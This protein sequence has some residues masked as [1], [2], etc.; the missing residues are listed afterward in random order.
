MA[1]ETRYTPNT[2]MVTISTSNKN[3]DGSGTMGSVITGA[4]NGTVIKSVMIKSQTST[5]EGMIRLFVYNGSSSFLV[6]ELSVPNITQSSRD[7]SF[8]INL[9][10][11]LFLQSG[12]ILKAATEV[13]QTFN[14]IALGLDISYSATARYDSTVYRFQNDYDTVSVAN[15]NLNGTGTIATIMQTDT[16]YI[17]AEIQRFFIK[18]IGTVTPGMVRLYI[19]NSAGSTTMLFSEIPVCANTP[20]ATAMSFEHVIFCKNFF[21]QSGYKLAASTENSE[22]FVVSIETIDFTYN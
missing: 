20:T 16:T 14:V 11:D 15:P 4:S 22:S 3:R 7:K 18:A 2:G 13:S 8:E 19:Q 17:G 10:L 6:A 1:E 21:L 5:T 12:D 9:D